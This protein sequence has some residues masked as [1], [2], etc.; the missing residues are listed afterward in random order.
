VHGACAPAP[1]SSSPCDGSKLSKRFRAVLLCVCVFVCV[2]VCVRVCV[3]VCIAFLYT[4]MAKSRAK[5][6]SGVE[7]LGGLAG[8]AGHVE[9]FT[10]ERV[11]LIS[12]QSSSALC[13]HMSLHVPLCP[14]CPSMFP[15]SLHVP[16]YIPLYPICP[17]G[18]L[19]R[20]NLISCQ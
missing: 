9:R 2:C 1:C 8:G 4:H 11:N 6:V 13:P 3:C 10:V 15:V 14:V 7:I 12:C 20:S 17:C 18:L 16:L 5:P 19:W